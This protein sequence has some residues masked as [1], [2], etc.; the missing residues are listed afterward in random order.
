MTMSN[1]AAKITPATTLATTPALSPAAAVSTAMDDPVQAGE[2]R[3]Q[4]L[5]LG[6]DSFGNPFYS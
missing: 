2:L 4:F 5:L 3:I 1:C 6:K